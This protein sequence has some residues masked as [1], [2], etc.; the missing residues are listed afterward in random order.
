VTFKDSK[1]R[2]IYL[3]HPAHKEFVALALPKIDKVLVVDYFAK[4]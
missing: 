1:A 4:K 3:P 2:D